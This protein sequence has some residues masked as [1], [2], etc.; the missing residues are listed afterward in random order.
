MPFV[1]LGCKTMDCTHGKDHAISRK[2]KGKS[3]K[4]KKKKKNGGQV[5]ITEIYN[6]I[7]TSLS[8]IFRGEVLFSYHPSFSL[9]LEIICMRKVW[10]KSVNSFKMLNRIFAERQK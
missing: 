7:F 2:I 8:Q 10:N 5:S 4:K 3:K 1:V 9:L 6:W